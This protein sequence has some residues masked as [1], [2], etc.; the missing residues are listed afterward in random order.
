M[1]A[2]TVTV[3]QPPSPPPH[4]EMRI[5]NLEGLEFLKTVKKN[6]VDL[7]ITDP[8]YI[9]SRESGMNKFVKE[10]A[11]IEQSGENK[12]TEEEWEAYKL[13]K[14][15]KT[16]KH[17][18]NYLQYGNTSGKKYATKTDYGEWDKT[19][20]LEE[21]EKFVKLYYKK[22][23]KGGTCIIFFDVWKISYLKEM[24]E[25]AKFKQIRLIEWVKSNPVPLNSSRNYLTNCREVAVLGVKVGKPTFHSKYDNGV[26][27]LGLEGKPIKTYPIQS[28]TK[29]IPRHPTEKSH[30]LIEDLICKHSN[31][32]DLVMDTFLGSGTTATACLK[33][34]RRFIGC[35]VNKKYF[36][37]I[38]QKHLPSVTSSKQ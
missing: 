23:R 27:G 22:L 12:K 29:G 30:A 15:I 5:E 1:E 9:I 31:E 6:S 7:I 19:F 28:K 36:E 35:E 32:N 17:K 13:K 20:T 34:N 14:K 25:R 8:P 4:P 18:K 21:L 24:M 3:T 37:E 33:T 11:K 26:Y 2:S 16:D 10:V 38:I